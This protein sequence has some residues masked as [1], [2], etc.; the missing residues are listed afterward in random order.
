VQQLSLSLEPGLA[1]K[2]RDMRECF[3]SCVYQ[4]GLGRVAAACD[5]QPSNLSSMLSGERNLDTSV[6]E[7]YMSEFDD[8]TPAQFWAAR[9]LQDSAA[10]SAQAMADIPA[11]VARLNNALASISGDPGHRRKR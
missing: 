8:K 3:A 6:I 11:I 7:K 9:E 2:Y 10:L 4:R 1:Q 5:V